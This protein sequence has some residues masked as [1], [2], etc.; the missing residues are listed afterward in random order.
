M[1]VMVNTVVSS[2]IVNST[3][4]IV[5]TRDTIFVK[6]TNVSCLNPGRQ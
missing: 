1:A 3:M 6:R 2:G 5:T 4:T